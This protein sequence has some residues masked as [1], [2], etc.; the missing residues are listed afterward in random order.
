[1]KGRAVALIPAAGQGRRMGG[2]VEKQFIQ[3]GG[4]P[5]LAA[6][7]TPFQQCQGIQDIVLVVPEAWVSMVRRSIVDRFG[8]SKV[9]KIVPGGPERQDSVRLGLHAVDWPCDLVL[10]HDGARPLVT[11]EIIL[12]SLR[13]TAVHGATLVGVPATDTIKDVDPDGR[14]RITLERGRLWMVQTPQTFR[15]ELI[16]RAHED[17]REAGFAGTD[18]AALVERLG[19]PVMA[20]MGSYDNIKV[21]TPRDLKL[22]EEV[23]AEREQAPAS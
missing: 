8:I 16:V 23:L 18:D 3:I 21:T 7:L 17:A 6:T 5:L 12:R 2:P 4:R 14:V 9:R 19:H 11:E 20:I 1:M 10:I 22:A 13:E 15:R